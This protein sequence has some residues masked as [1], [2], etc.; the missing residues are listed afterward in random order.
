MACPVSA[1]SQPLYRLGVLTGRAR[2]EANFVAFFDE[3]R[4]FGVLEGQQFVVDPR[5]FSKR[6]DQF[7][8]LATELVASDVNCILCAGD[9]AIRAALVAIE[10]ISILGISD[11]MVG[12]GLVRPLAVPDRN[13]T[14]VTMLATEL[15]G[16]RQEILLE[17][18]DKPRQIGALSDPRITTKKHFGIL[19]MAAKSN[20]V[21][22]SVYEAASPEE[23]IP[24]IDAAS[25]D[26]SQAL[27]VLA[28][29]LFSF[30]SGRIVQRTIFNRLP[31]IYQWPETAEE[32]GGLLGYGPR[33]TGMYRQM[34]R[35]FIKL[36]RGVK[37][38][39]IPVEQSTVFTMVANVKTAKAMGL[40]LPA[41][42]PTRSSSDPQAPTR[43]PD[44]AQQHARIS[45][46]PL[47]KFHRV[48][49]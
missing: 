48:M 34:A 16:K 40:E 27:N 30:N 15:N 11:D 19:Q 39:D 2:Q 49:W 20:G 1:F 28:S 6:E 46:N 3:L 44:D 41:P 37:P 47:N 10:S 22:L 33:I 7:P 43:P 17:V 23:I 5:G 8:A 24:A 31:A 29:P 45:S 35:Q 12:A 4:Q 14:G 42:A 32:Q 26:G 25:K 13:L 21:D 9:A 36:M 18:L 38:A